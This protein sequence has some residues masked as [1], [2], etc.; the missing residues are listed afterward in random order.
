MNVLVSLPILF[1]FLLN[2]CYLC[3]AQTLEQ[4][5]NQRCV[6]HQNIKINSLRKLLR[7]QTNSLNVSLFVLTLIDLRIKQ[8]IFAEAFS[9]MR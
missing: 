8:T 2:Y 6:I 4:T 9:L 5:A 7:L 1:S 3:R